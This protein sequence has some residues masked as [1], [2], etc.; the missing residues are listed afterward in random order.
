[1]FNVIREAP[2]AVADMSERQ[3]RVLVGNIKWMRHPHYA[4]V[5][6]EDRMQDVA[7][8]GKEIEQGQP[9]LR[10]IPTEGD[11]FTSLG[12]AIE[13]YAEIIKSSP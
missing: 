9:L 11:H 3:M 6:V 5:G 8:A 1:V 2:F 10:V 13:A 4:F 12:P 7:P